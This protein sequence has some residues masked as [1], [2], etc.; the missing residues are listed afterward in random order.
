MSVP[1]TLEFSGSLTDVP[2]IGSPSGFGTEGIDFDEIYA[3]QDRSRL[4]FT[5]ASDDPVS[6]P[7]IGPTQAQLIRFVCIEAT[8][9]VSL[10]YTDPRTS[11]PVTAVIPVRGSLWLGS[12]DVPITAIALTRS[13]GVSTTVTIFLGQTQ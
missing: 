3:L 1:S 9:Y 4:D 11:M 6:V 12:L 8:V 5:L 2:A 10:T 13:P 7:L